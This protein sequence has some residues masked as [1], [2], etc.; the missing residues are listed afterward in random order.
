M[1]NKLTNHPGTPDE[2]DLK[3][4]KKKPNDKLHKAHHQRFSPILSEECHSEE[5]MQVLAVDLK[6]RGWDFNTLIDCD[7]CGC[8]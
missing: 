5:R 4:I 7:T 8:T 2:I 1:K 3:K 6:T